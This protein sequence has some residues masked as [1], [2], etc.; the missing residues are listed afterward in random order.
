MPRQLDG[1]SLWRRLLSVQYFRIQSGTI[2]DTLTTAPVLGDGTETTIAVTAITNFTAADPVFVI[3]DGGVELFKIGTPNVT[4]PVT[5]KPKIPQS[6][7]ARFVEAAAVPLGKPSD[8]GITISPSKQLTEIFSSV[9][10]LPVAFI[11]GPVAL[12]IAVPLLEYSGLNWQLALGFAESESG[13]GS[14]ADPASIS[15]HG[16]TPVQGTTIFSFLGL[17]HDGKYQLVDLLDTRF[18]ASG[19]VAHNRKGPAIIPVSLKARGM[20][21]RQATTAIAH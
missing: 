2:G 6:T 9:D 13:A 16:Q 10:D 3:G 21:I 17:R 15:I 20:I 19:Q 1:T 11:D 18:E 8:E 5:F 14:A 4:M 7:G 12:G